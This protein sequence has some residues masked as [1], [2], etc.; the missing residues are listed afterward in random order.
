MAQQA[1]LELLDLLE[2]NAIEVWLD[3]G[4]AVDALLG[5]PHARMRMWISFSL[6]ADVGPLHAFA[7]PARLR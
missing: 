1:L 2:T 4:W 7:G 5:V 3:G 6:D